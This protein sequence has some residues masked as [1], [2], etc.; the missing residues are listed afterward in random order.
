MSV[1]VR[2]SKGVST[3]WQTSLVPSSSGS[4]SSLCSTWRQLLSFSVISLTLTRACGGGKEEWPLGC[5][6]LPPATACLVPASC[7]IWLLLCLT[8]LS[9]EWHRFDCQ[10]LNCITLNWL[11]LRQSS[12]HFI[13]QRGKNV[14]L[15]LT[16]LLLPPLTDVL[17]SLCSCQINVYNVMWNTL[18]QSFL[19]KAIMQELQE[20][21]PQLGSKTCVSDF[22]LLY[23]HFFNHV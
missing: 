8:F 1:P 13:L 10:Q 12:I 17:G 3:A 4:T 6:Y 18:A 16:Q 22:P 5:N 11:Q 2:T 14:S 20:W 21:C 15:L 19:V 23:G 9:G 7:H